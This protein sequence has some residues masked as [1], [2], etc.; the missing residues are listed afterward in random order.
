LLKDGSSLVAHLLQ[1]KYYPDG[2][3]FQASLGNRPS[4][5]WCGI[6]GVWDVIIRG[7]RRLVGDGRLLN[8]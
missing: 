3:I 4:F 1:A 7:S 8:I 5:T 2:D 6:L